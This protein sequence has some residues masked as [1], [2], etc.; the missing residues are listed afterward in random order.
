MQQFTK[1]I[2]LKS[3]PV[4]TLGVVITD[5]PLLFPD[6]F[7]V[8]LGDSVADLVA[9]FSPKNRKLTLL[10]LVLFF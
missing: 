6:S 8:V 3:L 1:N 7:V 10:E 2:N 5:D 9:A 4:P